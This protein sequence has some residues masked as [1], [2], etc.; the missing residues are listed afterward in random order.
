VLNL[1]TA[2]N[3]P[4]SSTS[5]R[6]WRSCTSIASSNR[7]KGKCPEPYTRE[8]VLERKFTELLKGISFSEEVLA[9]VTTALREGHGDEKKVHDEAIAN[10]QREDKR[11]QDRIDTMYLDK[12]DGR[13]E[14]EFFDR[15]AAEFRSDQCRIMRD[16]EAHRAANR[17]YIDEGIQLLDLS[18]RAHSLFESQPPSE[19]RKL[20]D[21]VVSNCRWKDRQLEAIYRHPFD[22]IALATQAGNRSGH[23]VDPESGHFD[24]WR[25][26]RDSNPR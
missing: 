9:W 5:L 11:I 19:K 7:F 3:A 2:S 17:S 10:L 12:L 6:I 24:S 1:N 21:F 18:R 15:K 4:R 13:I 22:L 25:R 23:A 8:D 26:G 16:L 20:L 14:A